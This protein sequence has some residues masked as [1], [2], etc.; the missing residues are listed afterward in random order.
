MWYSLSS[1]KVVPTIKLEGYSTNIL[2]PSFNVILYREKEEVIWL[3]Q[4][5]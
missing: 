4:L 2:T 3:I 5:A 1:T